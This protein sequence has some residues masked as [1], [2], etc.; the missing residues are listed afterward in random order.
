MSIVVDGVTLVEFDD[1]AARLGGGTC[2][3]NVEYL[4]K[5]GRF[6]AGTRLSPK[7]P[8]LYAKSAV[9]AWFEEVLAPVLAK[10]GREM[11]KGIDHGS[12]ARG[13]EERINDVR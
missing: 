7:G 1:F 4:S 9:D 12:A 3:R 13:E 11:P 8:F 5:K 10:R 6:P 2:A